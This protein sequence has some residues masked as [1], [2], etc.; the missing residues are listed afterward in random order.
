MLSLDLFILFFYS[1]DGS[2]KWTSFSITRLVSLGVIVIS[3]FA[4]SFGPFIAM[5]MYACTIIG[6][7][8]F[9]PLTQSDKHT[10]HHANW[11]LQPVTNSNGGTSVYAQSLVLVLLKSK[12]LLRRYY[13]LEQKSKIDQIGQSEL[14]ML[15]LHSFLDDLS[16]AKFWCCVDF[17]RKTIFYSYTPLKSLQWDNHKAISVIVIMT[18]AL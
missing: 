18:F 6:W 11:S 12:T 17:P 4:V 2:V 5:V 10:V 14:P 16:H 3:V 9:W 8:V 7:K 13:K 15:H 1:I